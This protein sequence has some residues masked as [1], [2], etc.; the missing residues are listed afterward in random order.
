MECVPERRR[1]S[2]PY[3]V[4]WNWELFKAC[5]YRCRYCPT[6][7]NAAAYLKLPSEEW[8]RIWTRLYEVYGCGEVRFTGGEPTLYPDFIGLVAAL[9]DMFT[10]NVTT[11]LSFDIDRWMEMVRPGDVFLSA[12]LHP[13]HVSPEEFL[14]KVL[15][16][17]ERE[18]FPTV[19]FVAF[20][21]HLPM[22]RDAQKMFEDAGVMFKI[23]PFDGEFEGRRFPAGYSPQ[24]KALLDRAAEESAEPATQAINKAFQDFGMKEG[25]GGKLCR[26]GEIYAKIDLDGTVRR[27]CSDG[28]E[29]LGKITDPGLRLHDEAQPCDAPCKCWKAMVVGEYEAK[30]AHLWH[31]PEHTLHKPDARPERESR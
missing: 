22:L 13:D 20:P 16:L 8:A 6:Y 10:I 14:K 25:K 30:A 5:N 11:N 28:A 3:R 19:A 9:Q 18:H 27:C 7:D 4:H 12:S 1:K 2:P 21:P 17:R 24:E 23:I 31:M 29:R 15:R 26:M